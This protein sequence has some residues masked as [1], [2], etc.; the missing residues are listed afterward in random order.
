MIEN[1][2]FAPLEG[3]TT[4]TFRSVFKKYFKGVDVYFSPFL[5][6]NHTH[7][8][9]TRDRA[10]CFPFQEDL[11]PQV[12]TNKTEDFLWAA[13]ALKEAGYGEI[14]LNLGC[15]SGTVVSKGRGSG[16]LK[17][18]M[19]LDRFLDGIFS[20]IDSDEMPHLS[21]K[22][23][24]GYDDENEA[25]D[26]AR[27][28]S[29]YPITEV[30]IHPRLGKDNYKGVPDMNAFRTMYEIIRSES[31]TVITYNGDLFSVDDVR[32]LS[33]AFPEIN[34]IMLGRGLLR[35]LFLASRIREEETGSNEGALIC[36]FLKE[37][38]E[39]YSA[40]LS[41]E[42][43]VLFKMKDLL[44]YMTGGYPPNLREVAAIKKARSKAEILSAADS[45]FMR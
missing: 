29:R 15:P 30:I 33:E 36:G 31:S 19:L 25:G 20:R 17:D 1:I 27:I 13:K 41:G 22:T 42:K 24:I 12:L 44:I 39:R 45:L 7:K 43:D 2:S 21:V 4:H 40:L 6:I 37:L 5:K 34:R 38:F 11:I 18:P 32:R 9:M 14:N 3:I 23:R 35:D 26:L 16:F 8:F 28:Y 10:E